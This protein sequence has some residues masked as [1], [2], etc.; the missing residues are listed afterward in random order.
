MLLSSMWISTEGWTCQASKQL[1]WSTAESVIQHLPF[2]ICLMKDRQLAG[3]G[4][5]SPPGKQCRIVPLWRTDH[6]MRQIPKA[7]EILANA[8]WCGTVS[9]NCVSGNRYTWEELGWCQSHTISM[10]T[11]TPWKRQPRIVSVSLTDSTADSRFS[12]LA[13]WVEVLRISI[14]SFFF[15]SWRHNIYHSFCMMIIWRQVHYCER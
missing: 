12:C 11:G 13:F 7:N 6:S 4:E 9:L 3:I 2:T 1:S 14:V 10:Q 5:E 15:G 8:S